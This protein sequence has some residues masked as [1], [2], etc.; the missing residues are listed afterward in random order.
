MDSPVAN[1]ET[2]LRVREVVE[3]GRAADAARLP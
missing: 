1:P 3:S 2:T